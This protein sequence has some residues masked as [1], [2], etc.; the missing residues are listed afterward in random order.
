M[1]FFELVLKEPETWTPTVHP[2]S[3]M[4]VHGELQL[5]DFMVTD[6]K[7]STFLGKED[8]R[9]MITRFDPQ[10]IGLKFGRGIPNWVNHIAEYVQVT[11]TGTLFSGVPIAVG[12]FI[13]FDG[14]FLRL[15]KANAETH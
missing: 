3:V 8:T 4:K 5:G 10:G 11:P 15:E 7:T 2:E 13:V 6:G 14:M 1:K 9:L 12:D